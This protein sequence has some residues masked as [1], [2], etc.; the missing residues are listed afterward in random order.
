MASTPADKY[1]SLA[2][3]MP[4]EWYDANGRIKS[5]NLPDIANQVDR[6]LREI[7]AVMIGDNQQAAKFLLKNHGQA[8]K[9]LLGTEGF[10]LPGKASSANDTK[11]SFTGI[12]QFGKSAFGATAGEIA[13]ALNYI[14][15]HGPS[16]D[17]D[18]LST[19]RGIVEKSGQN[20]DS[21]QFTKDN[22]NNFRDNPT[23]QTAGAII[24]PGPRLDKIDA[25]PLSQDQKIGL[26][27]ISHNIPALAEKIITA[28]KTGKDTNVAALSKSMHDMMKAN[29]GLYKGSETLLGI[30]SKATAY[31]RTM[32]DGITAMMDPGTALPAPAPAD[33]A[34]LKPIPAVDIVKKGPPEP[35]KDKL[36]TLPLVT[37]APDAPPTKPAPVMI[38]V[39]GGTPEVV[40]PMQ[41]PAALMTADAKAAKPAKPDYNSNGLGAIIT[42]D[43]AQP[44]VMP[45]PRPAELSIPAAGVQ[46]AAAKTKAPQPFTPPRGI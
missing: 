32:S 10:L 44:A 20:W 28:V 35:P 18:A 39:H 46:P 17:D 42:A 43:N 29:P 24:Y 11:G 2:P 41:R 40:M 13:D 12:F 36:M 15:A 14:K 23:V 4:A 27:L 8:I 3:G 22:L 1:A 34:A 38:T 33:Y 30:L 9:A 7:S 21:F 6:A 5:S 25:L 19:L 45:Y 16:Y 31:G 26:F 37:D